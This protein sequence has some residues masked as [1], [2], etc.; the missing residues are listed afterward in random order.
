[1]DFKESVQPT[2]NL[3]SKL[4]WDTSSEIMLWFRNREKEYKMA[5]QWQLN[6]I[7]CILKNYTTS[8]SS[9]NISLIN[10]INK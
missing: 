9:N 1:M 8:N 7:H 10:D 3:I 2:Q 6:K 5:L 4:A